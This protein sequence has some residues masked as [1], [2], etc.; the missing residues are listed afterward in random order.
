[1]LNDID[2]SIRNSRIRNLDNDFVYH[3]L[4]PNAF[5]LG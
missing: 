2:N 5:G 3:V 1:M 4:A